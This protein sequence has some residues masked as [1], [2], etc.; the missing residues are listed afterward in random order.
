MDS[1]E[2]NK[3]AGAGLFA[4]LVSFGLSI[5]SEMIFATDAPEAPGYM[6]AVAQSDE[7]HG[8]GGEAPAERPQIATLLASA[9]PGAG[10]AAAKKCEIGRA[11]CRERV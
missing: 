6:I 4:L 8:E 1:V 9:D 5:A 10:E 3:I 11:S 2:L 7:G